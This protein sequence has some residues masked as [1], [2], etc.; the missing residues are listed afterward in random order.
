MGLGPRAP[1]GAH[2]P[3]GKAL[4]ARDAAVRLLRGV[5]VERRSL[6]GLLE[7]DRA[8]LA[9]EPRDR[10]FARA[11]VGTALRRA[12]QIADALG[13]LITKPLPKRSGRL[14]QILEIA[15]AQILFLDVPPFAAVSSAVDQAGADRDARH[16]KGLA[17]AALRRLVENKEGFLAEQDAA[18]LN[19]PPWLRTRWV[20][21]YGEATTRAIAEA[22]MLEPSLDLSAKGDPAA[23]AALV[24]GRLLATGTLR[25]VPS[26][27]AEN[28]PG[29]A[30]G[31]WWVQD[32]AAALPARLLGDVAGK[33][34]ADLCAAPGGKTAALAASGA[35]V[36]A[37]DVSAARLKRL[38]A[39]L[40]RLGLSAETVAADLLTWDPP[41]AFDAVLL[42]APCTATGTIRRHPDISFLKRPEDIVALAATQA[43]MAD[44]AVALLKPG[45]TLVF[46]TCSLEPEEGEEQLARLLHRHNLQIVPVA[47]AEV[48]GLGELVTPAGAVRTLPSQLPDPAEPRLGGL[49]GFFIARLRKR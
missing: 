48:G 43:R 4:A 29:Y 38:S 20:A 12:G 44:K 21:T 46:C 26:G 23:L 1:E 11:L 8:F 42:D 17:N 47:A 18:A 6:D 37:L 33:R 3:S 41:E 14:R 34:V 28:L 15:A 10:A 24:N 49:D 35:S 40:A 31:A 2:P 27:P 19:L 39:N 16:F 25:L 7:S 45:G 36:T 9:L 13:R 5:T 30:D 32:A 22:L